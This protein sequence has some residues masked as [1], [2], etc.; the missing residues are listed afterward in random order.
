MGNGLASARVASPSISK[1][2][3]ADWREAGRFGVEE[4]ARLSKGEITVPPQSVRSGA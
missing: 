3:R 1:H 4:M 2:V